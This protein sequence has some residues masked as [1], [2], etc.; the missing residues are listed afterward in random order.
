MN[1]GI[2]TAGGLCPSLNTVVRSI[3][4]KEINKNEHKNVYGYEQGF[5]GLNNNVKRKLLEAD[6]SQLQDKPGTILHTS[7]ER[8]NIGHAAYTVFRC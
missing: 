6:V 8:L 3:V 5:W 1:I 7:R 4:L 2:L